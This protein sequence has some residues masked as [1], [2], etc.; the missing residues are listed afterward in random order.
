MFIPVY[1]VSAVVVE[2]VR[3]VAQRVATTSCL[4]QPSLRERR[5]PSHQ[6]K[7]REQ[8]KLSGDL[9]TSKYVVPNNGGPDDLNAC[10]DVIKL[11][12]AWTPC[13]VEQQGGL[14]TTTH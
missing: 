8:R 11:T 12:L 1:I 6:E 2:R 5:E 7:K 10:F 13:H 9:L 3:S 14:N 4:S